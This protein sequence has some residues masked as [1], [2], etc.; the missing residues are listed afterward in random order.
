VRTKG[1]AKEVR[2]GCE[3]TAIAHLC[4][5]KRCVLMQF[6]SPGVMPVALGAATP[7]G[8]VLPPAVP[9]SVDVDS[10]LESAGDLNVKS[11]ARVAWDVKER[12]RL[13]RLTKAEMLEDYLEFQRGVRALKTAKTAAD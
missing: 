9:R 4:L 12:Q 8:F 13:G 1:N 11:C 3:H 7:R 6:A 2:V 5:L 10:L